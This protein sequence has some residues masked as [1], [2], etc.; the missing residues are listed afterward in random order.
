MKMLCLCTLAY[1][2]AEMGKKSAPQGGTEGRAAPSHMLSPRS[3]T[4]SRCADRAR[5]PRQRLRRFR[6]MGAGKLQRRLLSRREALAVAGRWRSSAFKES[7]RSHI[8]MAPCRAFSTARR[9]GWGSAPRSDLRRPLAADRCL[10]RAEDL[11]RHQPHRHRTHTPRARVEKSRVC[12]ARRVRHLQDNA[13]AVCWAFRA[14][15][16]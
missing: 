11:L 6:P 14:P 15:A 8:E 4:D 13:P 12:F 2:R 1:V 16:R 5:R 3:S 9:R 10:R 7:A